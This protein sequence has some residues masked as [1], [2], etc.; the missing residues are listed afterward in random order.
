ML[1]LIG[2]G[3]E[4]HDLTIRAIDLIRSADKVYL[5]KYTSITENE[6]LLS[7]ILKVEIH[8]A[9]REDIEGVA[10][11]DPKVIEEAKVSHIA[12]IVVGTP[13]FATTHTEIMI[14]AQELG[15]KVNVL[16]NASIQNAFGCCG[17]NSYGFGRT[18]SIP[19][20]IPGWHPYD[21]YKNILLNYTTGMHTLCLLDIKIREPTIETL[22]GL[23]NRT[24][25]K[26]MTIPEALAQLKEAEEH[27][28]TENILGNKLVTIERLGT[29]TERF[30]YGTAEELS[31][32]SFGPPL[33]SL[34]IPA[35][36]MNK[37][38]KE[39]VERFFKAYKPEPF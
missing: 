17:F 22:Q 25:T 6:S 38:E 21:F 36:T 11:S 37:M 18:I 1:S 9:Y 31:S 10:D 19:F 2:L 14:R 39:C 27:F 23:E 13:L 20:F 12:L 3:L 7:E 4:P 29:Q 8:S 16:H 24:Y 15:I 5:E 30:F 26:Y 28:G 34:I 35:K 32:L 33:H